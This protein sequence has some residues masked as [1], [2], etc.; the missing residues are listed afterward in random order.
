MPLEL[1]R[2]VPDQP[3]PTDPAASTD[4]ADPA[5]LELLVSWVGPL[6]PADPTAPPLPR[7][8]YGAAVSTR[9]V[10]PGAYLLTPAAA[11]RA[12]PLV[13]LVARSSLVPGLPPHR[14]SWSVRL[15]ASA[16]TGSRP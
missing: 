12:V 4:P 1:V 14:P 5:P 2:L 9:D 11:P 10:P 13:V 3:L 16:P 6:P 15:R 8:R 7:Y